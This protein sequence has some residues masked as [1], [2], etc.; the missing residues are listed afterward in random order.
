MP[1]TLRV[2]IEGTYEEM[3]IQWTE[4][5]VLRNNPLITASRLKTLRPF[6]FLN[7]LCE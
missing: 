2:I 7:Q 5:I 6:K 1:I 4:T 3:A